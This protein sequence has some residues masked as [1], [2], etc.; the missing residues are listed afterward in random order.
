MADPD[1][2]RVA[3]AMHECAAEPRGDPAVTWSRHDLIIESGLHMT[4]SCLTT[5]LTTTKIPTMKILSSLRLPDRLLLVL[6]DALAHLK[7]DALPDPSIVLAVPRSGF[8]API[9]HNIIPHPFFCSDE[10]IN[11]CN[12][13]VSHTEDA[14]RLGVDRKSDD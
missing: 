11:L 7:L 12:G 1:A 5:V 8:S 2:A 3:A 14:G 13:D 4:C 10:P 6:E 9:L